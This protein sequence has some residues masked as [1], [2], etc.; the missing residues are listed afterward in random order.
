MDRQNNN[1]KEEFKTSEFGDIFSVCRKILLLLGIK[2]DTDLK[3]D[4]TKV[5]FTK[6]TIRSKYRFKTTENKKS[7][8]LANSHYYHHI[9]QKDDTSW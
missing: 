4:V 3:N 2:K 9:T 6:I 8:L 5:I 1:W 7:V